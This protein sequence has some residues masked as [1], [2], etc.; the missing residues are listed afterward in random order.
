ML[1]AVYLSDQIMSCFD[2]KCN[3]EGGIGLGWMYT[4]GRMSWM[5]ADDVW[6]M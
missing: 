1:I 6:I 2:I 4:L 5:T 3:G